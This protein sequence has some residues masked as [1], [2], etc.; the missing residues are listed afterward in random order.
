[1]SSG[2]DENQKQRIYKR[3]SLKKETEAQSVA[4]TV[5]F[6]LSQESSSI[7]GQ[8]LHVDNGTI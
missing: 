5:R 7:T 6:L 3:T 4:S 8:V 1:M 2:L